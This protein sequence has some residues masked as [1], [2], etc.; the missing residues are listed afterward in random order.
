MPT[1]NREEKGKLGWSTQ[2]QVLKYASG[3]A[4]EMRHIILNAPKTSLTILLKKNNGEKV[5]GEQHTI[6]A[7]AM[8]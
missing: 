2:S 3:A 5:I 1:K 6:K 4:T 8:A 7:W